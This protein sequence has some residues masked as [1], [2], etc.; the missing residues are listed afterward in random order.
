MK[1]YQDYKTVQEKIDVAAS[2]IRINGLSAT[3][4]YNDA[5]IDIENAGSDNNYVMLI[6]V[7]VNRFGQ[8]CE[9][10]G[11]NARDFGFDY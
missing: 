4:L 11:L 9:N 2:S 5:C 3:S 6:A 8:S 7:A 1:T 10:L